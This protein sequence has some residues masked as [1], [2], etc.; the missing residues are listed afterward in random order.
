MNQT[1]KTY[2]RQYSTPGKLTE[3]IIQALGRDI[4]YDGKFKCRENGLTIIGSIYDEV[5]CEESFDHDPEERLALLE[6]S[7]CHVEPWAEG[8]PLRAEGWYGPRYKKA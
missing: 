6:T 1:T 4:L 3:N 5:I 8:L 7:M 2:M